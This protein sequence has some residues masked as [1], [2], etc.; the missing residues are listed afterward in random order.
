MAC[1]KCEV[2]K[3]QSANNL[4]L[5][6]PASQ[7]ARTFAS[8]LSGCGFSAE[9]ILGLV[10]RATDGLQVGLATPSL[11]RSID[12]HMACTDVIF[13]WR[14]DPDFVDEQGEP[15]TLERRG[16]GCSFDELVHRAAPGRDADRLFEYLVGLCVIDR[17]PNGSC[18]LMTESVLA[19]S[20]T[21]GG[22]VASEVVLL[23]LLGFLGSVE[24]NL[25]SKTGNEAGRFERACYSR[26]PANLAPVFEKLVEARGQNFVDSVDEWLVRHRL[27]D[28]ESP[29]T[30]LVGAGAYLFV[31]S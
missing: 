9:D 31:R 22:Q 8:I 3:K 18:A 11:G 21:N 29:G 20:G 12:D 24:F 7:L 28:P 16:V 10:S 26:I 2:M 19:C 13:L 23:H 6:S 14:H 5:M 15:R 17:L 4:G 1:L 25:R 30:I 27:E